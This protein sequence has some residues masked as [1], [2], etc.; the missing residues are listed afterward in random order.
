[1]NGASSYFAKS[2][3]RCRVV[4]GIA[5]ALA[6]S[7]STGRARAAAPVPTE[8]DVAA[9]LGSPAALAAWIERHDPEVAIARAQ[10]AQASAEV[11]AAGLLPNPVLDIGVDNIPLG[12]TNP[13]GLGWSQT[14]VYS[15][16]LSET[17]ELGKRGPRADAA[18]LRFASA[19]QRMRGALVSRIAE[20]RLALG[21][22]VYFG[23]RQRLFEERLKA[24]QRIAAVEHT[25]LE[26]GAL[27]GHDHDRLLLETTNLGLEAVEASADYALALTECRAVMRAPC[28]AP[29]SANG[30]DTAAPVPATPPS[31]LAEPAEALALKLDGQAAR[32]DATLARRRAIPDPTFRIG[33][34]RSQFTISGDNAN[35]LSASLSVPLPI[36]DHG[37]ADLARATAR[38]QELDRAGD[39]YRTATRA[40]LEGYWTQKRG[41]E[42]NVGELEAHA[43]PR[44]AGVLSATEEAFKRGQ[45]DTTSLLLAQRA[46]R[47]LVQELLELRFKL[48]AVRNQLRRALELDLRAPK[49]P[50]S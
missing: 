37:Q 43:V 25:R 6:V 29:S 9:M 7:A 46:H 32:A 49:E 34:T 33:Y 14:N 30:L 3:A 24:A 18:R 41:L 8:V 26:Q 13:P 28:R 50:Q 1:M 11:R 44:S 17:F 19:E 40:L 12:R 36:F 48:F 10:I 23:A 15:V 16:G 47:A 22:V 42:A 20:A 38:A 35:T 4:T 39:A 5:L 27:S 31:S 2:R 21:R 45:A